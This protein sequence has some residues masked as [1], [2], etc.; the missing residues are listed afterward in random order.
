MNTTIEPTKVRD[1]LLNAQDFIFKDVKT[2][3]VI[4]FLLLLMFWMVMSKVL[5]V[6]DKMW[7]HFTMILMIFV[8]YAILVLIS[9]GLINLDWNSIL[10]AIRGFF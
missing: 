2:A 5:S 10:S 3:I 9:K 4:F 1:I 6:D 7:Q 8:F